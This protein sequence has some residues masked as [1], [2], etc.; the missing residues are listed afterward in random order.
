MRELE[1]RNLTMA[2]ILIV[3][4]EPAIRTMLEIALRKEGHRIET[5]ATLDAARR[6][7]AAA[8]YDVVISDLRL[9]SGEE[10]LE[11]LRESQRLGSDPA[12]ILI[13]GHHSLE[14]AIAAIKIGGAADYLIKGPDLVDQVLR[15]VHRVLDHQRIQ[16]ENQG[17]KRQLAQQQPLDN[18]IGGSPAMEKVR[19]S[20]RHLAASDSTVMIRGESGTGKE[21]A[22]R[23]LHQLSPRHDHPFIS[24][25]CGALPEGLLESELFGCVKGAYTGAWR[26]RRGL[27]EAA[28]GGTLLLDEIGDMPLSMQVALLR[29]LQERQVRPLG[30]DSQV[31]VDVRVLVATHADL[32]QAV[33]EGRFREDLYYRINVLPLEL[34]PLRQRRED[35]PPL[36]QFFLERFAKQSGK[37][38]K[39]F[40]AAGLERLQS[41]DWPGNVRQLEHAVER[42]VTLATGEEA[43]PEGFSDFSPARLAAPNGDANPR[44]PP[45]GLEAHLAHLE[46]Q[47]LAAA[48][49]QAGGVRT[50]AAELLGLTYRS[51]RHHAAKHGL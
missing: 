17:L 22:A 4:D 24:I 48:L 16:R 42:A 21:V 10:G 11:L 43:E 50:R 5:A 47:Y 26:N 1:S 13:T 12:F 29:V 36:A 20:I 30:A 9:E 33:R 46:R 51:F 18:L 15:S 2:L 39:R 19:A 31:P 49:A 38:V 3:D 35:V 34:P 7:L 37:P 8:L 27:F 25:N 14:S 23:A 44:L 45:E 40:S 28:H 6:K 41:H 32:E